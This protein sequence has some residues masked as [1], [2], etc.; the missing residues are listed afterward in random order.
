MQLIVQPVFVCDF[1]ITFITSL[2]AIPI[3][4]MRM[5]TCVF[6]WVDMSLQGELNYC[7]F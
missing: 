2:A 1:I 4:E 6:L 7:R 3:Q 5:N